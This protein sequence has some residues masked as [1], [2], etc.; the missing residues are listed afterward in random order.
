[1]LSVSLVVCYIYFIWITNS[2]IMFDSNKKN[3]WPN[4]PRISLII[5]IKKI[6][7]LLVIKFND[8]K[9]INKYEENLRNKTK[10]DA[11]IVHNTTM[12]VGF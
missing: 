4:N 3:H 7:I 2:F 12:S 5:I 9:W 1:M 8:V 11:C 10:V 6:C